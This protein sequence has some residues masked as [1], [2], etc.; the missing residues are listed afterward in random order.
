MNEIDVMLAQY[1]WSRARIL[2]LLEEIENEADPQAV[3]AWR[4]GE[5]RAHL[6][7]QLMH[8]GVTEELFATERLVPG[9]KPG[10][11][12]LISRFRGGST[13]DDDVP[14]AK[15]LREVLEGSRSHLTATL[16]R[17]GPEKLD[18]VPTPLAERS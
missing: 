16:G 18:K 4:P 15:L 10:W 11:P 6:A 9:S 5:R 1:E 12:E 8:V 3:L 14:S 7:W 17:F 2:G 13:P